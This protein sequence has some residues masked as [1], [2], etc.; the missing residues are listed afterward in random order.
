[1]SEDSTAL[2]GVEAVADSEETEQATN[3]TE[4]EGLADTEA[5]NQE[6]SG[7]DGENQEE[8]PEEIEFDF[9]GNKLK[10]PKGAIPEEV[11]AQ[12]DKFTKGTWSDYTRKSQEIAE[13]RKAL[14]AQKGA[15]ERLQTL[16]GEALETFAQGLAVQ[17]ELAQLSQI[18]LT[19]MWQSQDP[20]VRDRARMI[21]DAIAQKQAQLQ[22]IARTVSQTEQEL[23]KQQAAEMAR[24]EEEGKQV[25]ERRV[26]GFSQKA[27]E[28]VAYAI[29]SGIPEADAQKWAQNPTVTEFAYKAMLYDRMQANVKPKPAPNKAASAEP[30]VPVK[31]MKGSGGP[32]QKN[33]KD[34]SVA[35]MRKHL[36]IG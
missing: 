34:M 32:V 5:E 29:K 23:S 7:E 36:G 20:A 12:L 15:V 25:L 2:A 14:E 10:V 19:S 17:K 16:N 31:P 33:P 9:G 30:I 1:M 11:A 18:D 6:D 35:E 21:S 3:E 27:P 26:K 8:Q 13:S 28:V 24:L 4:T 22:S